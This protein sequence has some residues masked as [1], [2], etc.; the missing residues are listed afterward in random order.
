MV[1]RQPDSGSNLRDAVLDTEANR[2]N[3]D[4]MGQ[5]GTSKLLNNLHALELHRRLQARGIKNVNVLVVHPGGV[6]TDFVQNFKEDSS[7]RYIFGLVSSILMESH[8]G[9]LTQ[10]YAGFSPEIEAKGIS[11]KYIIPLGRVVEGPEFMILSKETFDPV[12][13]KQAWER[14]E[15]IIKN[16]PKFT[17]SG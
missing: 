7:E 10:L 8:D 4:F 17:T 13:G 14:G 9:A 16:W 6:R 12:L 11:G 5:Y 15:D 1:K 3:F 2:K